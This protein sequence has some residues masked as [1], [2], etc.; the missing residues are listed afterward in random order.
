MKN[1]K[2]Q[3]IRPKAVTI[4]PGI[5]IVIDLSNSILDNPIKY[6]KCFN[7]VVPDEISGITG[8][9]QVAIKTAAATYPI[10]DSHGG[11]FISGQMLVRSQFSCPD[12]RS[13]VY[14]IQFG[15]IGVGATAGS[16]FYARRGFKPRHTTI[17]VETVTFPPVAA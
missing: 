12:F 2:P 11:M 15:G 1:C 16:G 5:S 14:R 17:G 3:I 9:E 4:T 13:R 7:F 6:G 8:R 10:V